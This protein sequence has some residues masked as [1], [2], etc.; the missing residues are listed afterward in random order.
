L[1]FIASSRGTT[2]LPVVGN[3]ETSAALRFAEDDQSREQRGWV[4]RLTYS[5]E[6]NKPR[7]IPTLI[8]S[9][10]RLKKRRT[11]SEQTWDLG[12]YVVG[13]GWWRHD[14]GNGSSSAARQIR[15]LAVPM[16]GLES[17]RAGAPNHP[18]F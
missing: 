12:S 13:L 15:Y 8:T 17:K 2:P 18:M 16:G 3:G 4:E 10:R 7:G 9:G 5:R 6:V 1:S 14:L 11:A